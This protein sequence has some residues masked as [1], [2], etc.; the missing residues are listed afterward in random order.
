MKWAEK[1]HGLLSV[2]GETCLI[3]GRDSRYRAASFLPVRN[4][5]PR[6]ALRTLCAS[7]LARIPWILSI[8]CPVCGRPE[9]CGDCLR[10]WERH[11]VC[12]RGAVRYDDAMKEWLAVYKYRGLEKLEPILAAMLSTAVEML[13][14]PLQD[15]VDVIT[16]VPLAEGRLEERGFNQAERL[17]RRVAQWYGLPYEP[18]LRRAR[19]TEKQS[20]KSRKDRLEDMKGTFALLEERN[21]PYA[22]AGTVPTS[23]PFSASAY[24]RPLPGASARPLRILLVDDIYTTGSTM[25]ECASVLRRG[26]PGCEIYGALWARS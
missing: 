18:M 4:A 7:C 10:R 19:H 20:F 15:G 13:L 2:G 26:Y 17:S 24:P 1:L 21:V 8:S 9:R 14:N 5:G 6:K 23:V 25:N 3:C 16:S 12:C 22:M 11:F